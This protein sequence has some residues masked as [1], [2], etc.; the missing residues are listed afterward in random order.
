MI[1]ILLIILLI[2]T[3]FIIL[4]YSINCYKN[5][6]QYDELTSINSIPKV[7]Y[8][9]DKTLDNIKIYSLNWKKLNPE[10]EIKLYDNAL[11]EEFLLK[12][13]QQIHYDI[14]T[15]IKD[16]PIKADFWR[17]CVLYIYGGVYID[18]DNEP[19]IPLRDFIVEDA[20]FVTCSSYWNDMNFSFNPNFIMAKAGDSILKQCIELY[21]SWYKD[22]KAYTY[23]SWSIMRVFS[24]LIKLE[25]YN[26]MYGI[27]YDKDKNK[28]YQILME[29]KGS[30]KYDDHNIYNN[31]RVFNNRYI[32]Y[33]EQNHE[34]K[35]KY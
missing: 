8:M 6:R 35:K 33:D 18:S 21:I 2:I 23:W 17:L 12:E 32:D 1:N 31:V 16:G 15:Y 24:D 22:K 25:N 20:D 7:I 34:F 26:K 30:D 9:C 10:Y 11:C 28:K 13:F 3:I 27:Y 14:F 29:V 4:L 19:L 5:P